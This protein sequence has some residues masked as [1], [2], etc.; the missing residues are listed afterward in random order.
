ME[1]LENPDYAD[2]NRATPNGYSPIVRELV[3]RNESEGADQRHLWAKI[4]EHGDLIISGH[5]LGPIVEK[6]FGDSDYEWSHTVPGASVPQ[7]LQML[8]GEPGADAM[9]VL[10]QYV[11]A[12]SFEIG[13]V[14]QEAAKVLPVGFWSWV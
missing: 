10:S 6:I 7:F 5:D 14:L 4:D 8:G 1:W 2:L 9:I 11:D 3:L 13:R 12:R